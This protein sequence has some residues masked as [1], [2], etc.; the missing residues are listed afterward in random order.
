[1]TAPHRERAVATVLTA[2]GFDFHLFRERR[3]LVWRGKVVERLRPV[4]PGYCFVAARGWWDLIRSIGGV[5][6]FVE[7]GGKVFVDDR[8]VNALVQASVDDVLPVQVKPIACRF[9]HGDAVRIQGTS[10]WAGQAG[11]FDRML[12]AHQ[13]VIEVDCFGRW[14]SV[15]CDQRDLERDIARRRRKRKRP[16]R[17]YRDRL[18]YSAATVSPTGL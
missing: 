2:Y 7:L 6:G 4:F 13:C 9:E 15:P 5:L 8:V 18:R 14:I 12:I 16:S 17:A 1:M 11:R 3:Q 10:V